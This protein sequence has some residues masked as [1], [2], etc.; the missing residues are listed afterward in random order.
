VS[1]SFHD[2]KVMA[3]FLALLPS[4]LTRGLES[5][6]NPG[7]LTPEPERLKPEWNW[8]SF[9]L[10]DL[11][12]VA[13]YRSSRMLSQTSGRSR[14]GVSVIREQCRLGMITSPASG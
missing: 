8:A 4:A 2:L 10:H 6:N 12:V 11:K 5:E 14:L 13:I 9:W 7:V 1:F 3:M